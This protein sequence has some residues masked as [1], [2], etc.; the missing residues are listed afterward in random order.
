MLNHKIRSKVTRENWALDRILTEQADAINNKINEETAHERIKKLA[1]RKPTR[2]PTIKMT[3][4][5]AAGIQR[6]TPLSCDNSGKK[7]HYARA[8]W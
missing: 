5:G 6:N 1:L 2:H 4:V 7:N 8:P 3:H